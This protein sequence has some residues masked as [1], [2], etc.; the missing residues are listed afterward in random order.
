M[1]E[2][3]FDSFIEMTSRMVVLPALQSKPRPCVHVNC[4]AVAWSTVLARYGSNI[5]TSL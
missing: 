1:Q 2:M 4:A 5:Y 3:L